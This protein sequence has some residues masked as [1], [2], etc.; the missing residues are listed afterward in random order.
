[1]SSI[2]SCP[3]DIL[4][5]QRCTQ[6]QYSS[7]LEY[8]GKRWRPWRWTSGAEN[9][10]PGSTEH[11]AWVVWR[12]SPLILGNPYSEER[13]VKVKVIQSCLTVCNPMDSTVHGI[14]QARILRWVGFFF[15]RVSSQPRHRTQVSHIACRFFT[16]WAT[17][18]LAKWAQK[19]IVRRVGTIYFTSA[20]WIVTIN[21][22]SL[23]HIKLNF[24]RR[25]LNESKV[26][27]FFFH[28]KNILWFFPWEI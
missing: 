4:E 12:Y 17:E 11:I 10:C 7:H 23:Y 22:C 28:F 25:V 21:I 9:L 13:K 8:P 3:W 19:R 14:L 5:I 20:C 18:V 27:F 15:S 24:K 6:L 16:S 2:L 1:M 26:V